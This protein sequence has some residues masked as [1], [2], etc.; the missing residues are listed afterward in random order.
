MQKLREAIDELEAQ[1]GLDVRELSALGDRLQALICREAREAVRRGDHQVEGKTPNGWVASACRISGSSAADRLRVGEQL[2]NL[3]RIASGL[4]SGEIGYQA[5]AVIC[6]L[7]DLLG[8]KRDLLEEEQWLAYA[9]QF[10][11]KNL[12]R[13]AEHA[14][15]VAD[16]DGAEHNYE[17]ESEQ[18]YLFL[19][20]LGSMYKLDALLDRECGVALKAALE[21]LTRRLGPLDVRAPRQRRADAFKEMVQHVLDKGSLPK[22]NGARPQVIVHTTP[23]GLKGEL[24]DGMPVPGKTVQRL[25]CDCAMHRVVKAGSMVID[26]G[27]AKRTA[28]PAQ[29]RAIKARHRTCAAPGCERPIG[30]TQAHHVEFWSQ[31]GETNAHRLVPLCYYHHRLVH[32]GGWQVVMVGERVEF[33]PPESPVMIRRRWGERRWA[34]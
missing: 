24:S 9:Q 20:E 4:R 18:R 23:E 5:A 22:R 7:S 11:I 25:A 8:E 29:W 28:Q 2:D 1:A 12:R 10:S 6:H 21:T 15:Y 26:V 32:E 13:L 31:G 30:W 27:R 34:A 33:V 14:R 3:P 19:S 16:P 17:E